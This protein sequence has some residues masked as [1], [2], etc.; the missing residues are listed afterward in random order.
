MLTKII[1]VYPGLQGL[2]RYE[3]FS[4]KSGNFQAKWDELFTLGFS[5]IYYLL[6]G[7]G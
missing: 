6:S 5:S 2:L 7:D 1:S 3:I 4:A